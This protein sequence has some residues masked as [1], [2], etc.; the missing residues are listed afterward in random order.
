MEH[1]TLTNDEITARRARAES[2]AVRFTKSEAEALKAAAAEKGVPFREWMRERL[3]AALQDEGDDMLLTEL[4]GQF[5]FAQWS[6]R[7]LLSAY[8]V[9]PQ[10]IDD[11]LQYI[12]A[13]KHTEA[14]A[15]RQRYLDRNGRS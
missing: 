13:Q 7:I 4:T 5:M 15:L 1:K 3:L 9:P 6:L 14:T 8:Q 10:V 2:L 11:K 12:R